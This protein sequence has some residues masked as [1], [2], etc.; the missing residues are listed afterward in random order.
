MTPPFFVLASDCVAIIQTNH[1]QNSL[2]NTIRYTEDYMEIK[3]KVLRLKRFS[4]SY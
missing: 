2:I 1:I 4:P 3:D